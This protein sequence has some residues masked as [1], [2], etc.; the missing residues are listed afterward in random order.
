V[1]LWKACLASKRPLS[2]YES[3]GG[4][5]SASFVISAWMI[6]RR[7]RLFLEVLVRS[8]L[9]SSL[10]ASVV[11]AAVGVSSDVKVSGDV[12]TVGANRMCLLGDKD[13]AGSVG[14]CG[15]IG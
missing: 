13:C 12:G 4:G 10:C 9:L 15:D 7:V 8:E 1:D 14:V 5:M 6:S 11:E 2:Q 3:D